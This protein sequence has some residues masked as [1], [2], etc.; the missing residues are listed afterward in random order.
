MKTSEK[1]TAIGTLTYAKADIKTLLKHLINQIKP[2]EDT[3]NGSKRK[4]NSRNFRKNHG[5]A[6]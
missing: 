6:V 3:V 5:G 4:S 1:K 2:K